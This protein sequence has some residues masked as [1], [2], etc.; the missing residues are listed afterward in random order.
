[1]AERLGGPVTDIIT[2]LAWL[3]RLAVGRWLPRQPVALVRAAWAFPVVGALVG[4]AA[5]AVL[6]GALGL[7]LSPLLG[8]FLAIAV[9]IALIGGLHEDGLADYVDGMGARTRERALDIMRD[10]RIGAYG[11]LALVFSVG[12]R[13]AGVAALA[14][15][16]GWL[17]LAGL[18]AAAAL[19]RAGMV[20]AL[21]GLPAARHDGLGHAAGRPGRGVVAIAV[22]IGVAAA[23]WPAVLLARPLAWFAA[24]FCC[25]LAQIWL[26][27][28]ARR[29]LGGQTGDVLGAIQQV[30]EIAALIALSACAGPSPA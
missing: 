6:A 8:G 29:R 25:G 2:A 19:S 9:M 23:I 27:R 14:A 21:A 4:L 10:S 24:V 13:V 30:G 7:G 26:A 3:T 12:L 16:S 22:V 11:V 28:Q 20:A 1:M 18:I 17:A 5:G 15:V